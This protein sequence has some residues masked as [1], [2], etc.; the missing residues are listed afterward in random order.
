MASRWHRRTAIAIGVVAVFGSV[1][2]LGPFVLDVIQQARRERDLIGAWTVDG[3]RTGAMMISSTQMISS[4]HG[5]VFRQIEFREDGTFWWMEPGERHR[6]DGPWTFQV[7]GRH[8]VLARPKSEASL[9]AEWIFA[10]ENN[11]RLLL[12]ND[13]KPHEIGCVLRRIDFD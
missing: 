1:V 8:I 7:S 5:I 6:Y 2:G 12:S 3:A 9:D 13:S 11:D 4:T 10:F